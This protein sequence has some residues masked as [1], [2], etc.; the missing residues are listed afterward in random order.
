M[1][2]CLDEAAEELDEQ[3]EQRRAILLISDGF[4]HGSRVG[5]DPTV[6]RVLDA[7]ATIYAIDLAPM[8][9]KKSLGQDQEVRAKQVMRAL[10]E[11][12][13]GRYFASRG[14]DD[15]RSAFEAI[16][17]ELGNQYT[18]GYYS[19]NTRND[20]KWRKISVTSG[21]PGL[22]LRTRAG[23]TAPRE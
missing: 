14:G 11:K 19:S 16:I 13:G 21:R 15:L 17:E 18:L 4:D 3:P 1:Y 7:G 2:D 12:S 8:G 5:Y 22:Q 6:R 20:G 23:Y 9:G 10:A